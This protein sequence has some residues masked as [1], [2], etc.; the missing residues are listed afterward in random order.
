MW[1]PLRASPVDIS[2]LVQDREDGQP[3][4]DSEV[5]V[6]LRRDGGRTVGGPAT[7]AVA[8]S[9]LLYCTAVHLPK[10]WPWVLEVTVTTFV[11]ISFMT[12]FYRHTGGGLR[13]YMEQVMEDTRMLGECYTPT[14]EHIASTSAAS[15]RRVQS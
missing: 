8:Q 15:A 14:K 10:A 2:V 6:W 13:Q 11:I 4:L 12:G 7:R 5:S 1:C 3:V 9:K